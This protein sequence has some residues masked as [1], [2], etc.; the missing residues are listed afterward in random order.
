M[1]QIDPNLWVDTYGDALYS[2]ALFR[3]EN[4]P[5]AE[6]LVQETFVAALGARD[7]FTGRSSE[8]TWFFSILKNK[9][10]D[11]LRL[12]YK[13]H[14]VPFDDQSGAV[15]D[16]FFDDGG[17]WKT[18]PGRWEENPQRNFE[19][20][21]FFTVLKKC[22]S[23]LPVKQGQVFLMRELD[24]LAAEEICKVLALSST[25]YWVVMHRARLRIR[26]CLENS[27]F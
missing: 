4:K 6:E 9:I 24:D 5:L 2:Y 12:K 11:H 13:E 1:N 26:K 20:K 3:L 23:H 15:E 17:A 19:E 21:E 25:N 16:E 27:W 14:Q 22:V 8:K 7:G 18:T 10:Y